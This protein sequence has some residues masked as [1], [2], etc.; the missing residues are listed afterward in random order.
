MRFACLISCLINPCWPRK[1]TTKQFVLVNSLLY[2][3]KLNRCIVKLLGVQ[4]DSKGEE[5]YQ[6]A[7]CRLQSEKQ[8]QRRLLLVNLVNRFKKEQLVIDSKQQL[9]RKVVDKD[10]RDVLERSD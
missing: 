4:G 9:S 2:I 1:L 3:V 5:K 7:C 8:Q 6:K 10:T